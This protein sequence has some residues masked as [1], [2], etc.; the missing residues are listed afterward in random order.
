MSAN[1]SHTSHDTQKSPTGS[2]HAHQVSIERADRPI[3]VDVD[4]VLTS[5][6]RMA[7]VGPNGVGKTTLF[8]VLAGELDPDRGT[9]RRS[10]Y[11]TTVGYV[12]QELDRDVADTA[13]HLVAIRTGVHAAN[14]AFE[15]ATKDL[16]DGADG[17]EERYADALD[18]WLAIGA[19]D[20]DSRLEAVADQIGLAQPTLDLDPQA[21]SGG[22]AARVGLAAVMLSR[23][24][25]TLLDEPT[26]DLD[27]AGLDLLERWVLGHQGGLAVVSHDRAFLERTVSS[28]LEIDEHAHTT[29]LFN[30]G[31]SSFIEE[32]QRARAIEEERYGNYVGQR[33]KL[34]ARAQQQHEWAD[35]GLSRATKAPRD[36]DKFIKAFNIAQ[37]ES[38][39]GRARNTQKAIDRLEVVDKPW[40][41]WDLQFTIEQAPRS[42][43]VVAA[44]DKAVIERGDFRLGP[45]DLEIQWAARI[46]LTG[47]NGCGKSSIIAALLGTLEVLSGTAMLGS[48]V[49]V[50]QLDQRRGLLAAAD[51]P[52]LDVFQELTD[53]IVSDARSVLAKFGVDA[54]AVA[55]HATQL[56]PGERTR[57]QLALFQA[58][59]VNFLVLD[60]P[61]NHLDLPA[62][63]QLESALSS[64]D[65]TLLLVT[66]DRRLLEAVEVTQRIDVTSF[67]YGN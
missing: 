29:R 52:L 26:N 50:G 6:S 38:L 42:A 40:E 5:S 27:L 17:A 2:L 23:F 56:S 48:G 15:A 7:V 59:G 13:R 57:A 3:L 39:A 67:S 10:P 22:Q 31:W 28:V 19:A 60:E 44:L 45:I 62:I 1:S 24:D 51:R 16:G 41:G 33:D 25:I 32:R 64:Y 20:F 65:G 11:S 47:P 36:N 8:R 37:T 55:R 30:G 43:T 35:R 63:E 66:H 49:V 61:S 54:R 14:V 53:L 34:K 4:L 46:A 12:R 18:H 21:L 58:S 9:V